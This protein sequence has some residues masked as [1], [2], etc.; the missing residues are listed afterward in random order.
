MI[1]LKTIPLLF[2]ISL[3]LHAQFTPEKHIRIVVQGSSQNVP[4]DSFGARPKVIHR[5]GDKYARIEEE[6]NK[7][8]NLQLL[9]VTKFPDTWMVNL[10]D[11]TGKHIVDSDPKGKVHF[12]IFPTDGMPT[13]FSSI[14][15]KL[16]FGKEVD[17]FDSFKSPCEPFRP[18]GQELVKQ[19]VGAEGWGVALIRKSSTS[20]P[21]ML[22]LFKNSEIVA[23]FKYLDYQI[24]EQP[25]YTLFEQPKDIK[26]AE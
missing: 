17:F 12:P 20:S 6:L 19:Y 22:F 8:T 11:K 26:F 13:S 18:S 14:L 7:Q 3:G 10:F 4:E 9:I 23:A 1:R 25:N 5:I 16:E 15:G 21:M 24:L 2:L